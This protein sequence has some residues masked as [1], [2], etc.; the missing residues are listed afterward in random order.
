MRREDYFF[1]EESPIAPGYYV[2]QFDPDKMPPM[3]TYGSFGILPARLMNLSYAQ[4]LRF[5]RDIIGAEL[6]G[7]NTK[8]PF[9]RFKKTKE[10][11]AFVRLLNTRMYCVLWEKEH[12]DWREHQEYL[13]QKNKEADKDVS[14]S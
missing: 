12:P 14:N 11:V 7:K 5:C 13:A 1:I 2:I 3:Q 8:Y 10:L 9:P 4:Y 6:V